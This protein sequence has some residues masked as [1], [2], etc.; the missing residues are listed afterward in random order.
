MG[1]LSFCVLTMV[2]ATDIC[3]YPMY[4]SFGRELKAQ[5]E[6]Q[7]LGIPEFVPMKQV[8]VDEDG[9]PKPSL[10]PALHNLIFVHS[11]RQQITQLKMY[12][13]E[14]QHLQYM[15]RQSDFDQIEREVI[16][17][18]DRQMTNFMRVTREANEHVQWLQLT[19]FLMKEGH[20]VRITAGTFA[21]VEAQ[22]K[23]IHKNRVVVVMLKGIAAVAVTH[24]PP[25][26]LE[27]I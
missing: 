18:P 20:A 13:R 24:V 6:L 5:A 10:V 3:W 1:T 19:D 25:A 14:C 9:S 11:S 23:R 21:G 15:T 22:V 12:N 4:A 27:F 26:Y 17:V 7:R 8:L 2:A 16:T